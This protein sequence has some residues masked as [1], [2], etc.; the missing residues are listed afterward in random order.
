MDLLWKDI[1]YSIHSL[2]ANPAFALVAILTLA[3]GIGATTAIF[4]VV[5]GVL[6]QPL[7]L[8][9]PDRLVMVW[10]NRPNE[11]DN[12]PNVTSPRNYA[13]W[14]RQTTNVFSSI[15]VLFDWEVSLTGHGD[16][17]LVR[18]GW[19]TPS[20]F[21]T[22]GAKPYLGRAFQSAEETNVVLSHRLWQR[23][24]GSDP[25]AVGKRVQIDG[26]TYTVVGVMPREFLIPKSRA[27]MW[28]PFEPPPTARGRYLT[29]IARLKPGVTLQQ[30][31][32]AMTVVAQRLAAANPEYN[33]QWGAIV[34]PAHEQVVGNVR[35]VLLIVLAAVALL[36]LIACVNIAN[37]LLSRATA[38]ARE[39]AIRSALGATRGQLIRQLL[40]ESLILATIAGILG[41]L[42]AGW[43][44]LLLVR[45]TPQSVMMPRLAEIAIDG[46]VLGA[47]AVLTLLTGIFFGVVPA[48]R[49][50][51]V[52]LQTS[53]KSS[54]R[55]SS[56]DRSGKMFRNGLVMVEVALATVLLI[57][58]GLLIKS[59]SKLESVDPGVR[60]GNVL[61][62]RLVL[63]NAYN[64][65]ERRKAMLDRILAEV[66]N[67]PGVERV[68]AA[69][70]MPFTDSL[71]RQSLRI[72]GAPEPAPGNEPGADIRPIAGDYFR[73]M[74]IPL[75]AGR[76]IDPSRAPMIRRDNG[77]DT[78]D[79][80]HPIEIVV[81]Q[82]FVRQYFPD[83]NAVGRHILI[84]W[85]GNFR[86]QI[87]GVVGNVRGAGLEKDEA[88]AL[89]FSYLLDLNT[90]FT[91]TI[92]T[93]GDPRALQVPVSRV[94][95]SI[96]PLMPVS[97]VKTLDNLISGTIARP[98]FN[99]TML[100][101][102]AAL[103]LLLASIG[104]YGVLS[105][106]VAQRTQEMGI[107]MALGADPG[108]VLRLVVRDGM[109]VALLGVGLGIVVALPAA[110]VL[111]AL[112]YGV[113]ASDVTV[114]AAVAATLA[115]VAL[116]SSWIP[117]R[118]ATRVDPMLALRP[119]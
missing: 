83:G 109:K 12:E 86:A 17:E 44:T 107:R 82:E 30:A 2:R 75:V 68:G 9:D 113:K 50:S 54:S 26:D 20:L 4:S 10:E 103:G 19:A 62:M 11:P 80:V 41:V 88:T 60:G 56:H 45:F 13:E 24:F 7:P 3:L 39:M 51:R 115:L 35:R 33:G 47:T 66:G 76:T 8:H 93:K 117:A 15:G 27:E 95:R 100:T 28:M 42:L 85:F 57:G 102:F 21:A 59:F 89:Y 34:I 25:K 23:K 101:L 78:P 92:A 22:L 5:N 18:A 72:E 77:P 16:P 6:L 73:A 61:T 96:D 74:G 104:I 69:S 87:V 48:L 31:Q 43:A 46:R 67:L 64:A 32:A 1:R 94:L 38:R 65:P 119:E 91:L 81:N 49:V 116:V 108:D 63:T 99:A 71:S 29:P 53:L 110:R 118:R 97:D 84:E 111:E 98:R 106:S 14:V 105:Y 79:V 114:F 70:S 112:L 90:Q 36:L 40:T 37:L 52:D 58:A 55:G